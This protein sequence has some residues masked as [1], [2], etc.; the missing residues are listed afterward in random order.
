MK[1]RLAGAK[2]QYVLGMF[3]AGLKPFPF[4]GIEFS[5]AREVVPDTRAEL[6]QID[7]SCLRRRAGWVRAATFELTTFMHSQ[8][9]E[10]IVA[11]KM[12]L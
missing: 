12:A 4:Q 3:V 11:S 8:P 1:G 7:N 9:S 10:L 5:A 6:S 2:A